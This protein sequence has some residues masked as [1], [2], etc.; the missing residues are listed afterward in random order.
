M[1]GRYDDS[2]TVEEW[3][4]CS[5]KRIRRQKYCLMVRPRDGGYF[6]WVDGM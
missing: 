5:W 4:W 1:E 3:K 6:R 2:D